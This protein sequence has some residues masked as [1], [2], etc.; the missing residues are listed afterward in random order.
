MSEKPVSEKK[1]ALTSLRN[2]PWMVSTFVLGALFLVA[3]F[4]ATNGT[5]ASLSGD[6]VSQKVLTALNAQT[7]GGVTLNSVSQEGGLYR[8]DVSYQGDIV[9]VYATLD[10]TRLAFQVIPLDGSQPLPEQQPSVVPSTEP[11][12]IDPARLANAP[13]KGNANAPITIVEFSDYECPFC[14]RFYTQTL[15]SIEQQYIAT[16]KVKFIYMNFPLSFHPDAQ[17]A[18]ESALCVWAQKGNDGYWDMHDALFENQA[19]LSITNLKVLARGLSVD[20]TRFDQCL[21]SGQFTQRVQDELAYGQELGVTGTPAFF[22]NGQE[23][24]G[25]QPFSAFEQV[26]EAELA[27]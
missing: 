21:D 10:G 23:L 7:G 12:V 24:V 9:P 19:D 15:P 6:D 3:L 1:S 18:A 25:A 16:D 17:K 26:I 11:K 14:E 22:I 2:N 8:V 4:F 27:A 5:Q 20:G 13:F